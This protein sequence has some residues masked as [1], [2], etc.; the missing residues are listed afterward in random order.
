MK[1]QLRGV[2]REQR[3]QVEEGRDTKPSDGTQ[4]QRMSAKELQQQDIRTVFS[5]G[6][7]KEEREPDAS[8][9]D[10]E[11]RNPTEEEELTKLVSSIERGPLQDQIVNHWLRLTRGDF[12]T[13]QGS[14]YINDQIIDSYMRLVQERSQRDQK[15]LRTYA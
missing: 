6:G 5:K 7:E 4:K 10:S 15:L 14:E 1:S 12:R 13:L 2:E 3:Q 8:Q 9:E 11:E